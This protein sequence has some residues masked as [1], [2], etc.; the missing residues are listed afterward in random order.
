M[1]SLGAT[2]SYWFCGGFCH[3][4]QKDAVQAYDNSGHNKVACISCHLPVNADPVT[5]LYHKAHA[6]IVGAY[7]LATKTYAVPLNAES[8]LA[9]N[10]GH[11]GDKQCTQCHNLANRPV[12]PS[13]G[14]IINHDIHTEKHVH[15]TACHN[16]VAHPEGDIEIFTKNPVTGERAAYHAD[17][18]TMTACFRCHTLTEESPSGEEFKAPG[19][20]SAC[21]PADFDLK[22]ANHKED[23]FYPKGHADLAMMEVDHATG[24]PDEDI[25]R[26]IA[27][28]EP[29]DSEETTAEAEAE[30]RPMARGA[31]GPDYAPEGSDS[32]VLELVGVQEVDYC[33]TCHVIDTFCMDCHGMEMP[34][35]T[36]FE[37]KTHP[38]F[39]ATQIEKCEMCHKQSETFFC[40]SCHHGSQVDWEYDPQVAWQTQHATTVVEKGVAPCTA[41]CHEAQFCVDCHTSLQPVPTSHRAADW[42]HKDLTVTKYPSTP[43]AA[44][45]AHALSARK[46][47]DS[48][49][50]CHGP[51]GIQAAFCTGCHGMEIPHPDT[52]KTNHVSGRNTPALCSN[53]HRQ[54]ELCSDCHHEGAQN[55][56]PWAR[57]HP[58]TV[59]A[60]GAQPCFEQCHENKQF[61][62]DCHVSLNALPTSHTAA[63]WTKRTAFSSPAK[64]QVA[65]KA[66]QDS[67]DYCHGEGGV[68]AQF[69]QSCHKLEMPHPAG[70]DQAHKADFEA[71][72]YDRAVCTN[73]HVQ[74]YCDACHHTG[75]VQ[76]Q[77]WRTYHPGIV[78]KDGAQPCFECHEPT[79]CAFCHV[80]L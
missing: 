71:K 78:K 76:Q 36:E 49:D 61:C 26:P 18:M 30:G 64:H 42:L 19:K 63:D 52:F 33:G 79:F 40:D 12:T 60:T 15:C 3:S 32:H 16:R 23:G 55:G 54:A 62:V 68:K 58:V 7:Q 72:T 67:C 38:E 56:V 10:S 2:S 74:Y 53:C 69:C 66:A 31:K 35:T 65:Y 39:V 4:V 44:S 48:C 13:E 59:A 1:I 34:H 75:A 70:F 80:R 29:Y 14:I 50:V 51:G 9:L 25:I 77:P 11:M 43:A 5:F 17:F 24:R 41:A 20:C 21:H 6:G 46:S 57:Q 47:M 45:A 27:H 37:T 73:C 22:P 8:H 28:G